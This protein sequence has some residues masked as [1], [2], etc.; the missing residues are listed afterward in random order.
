M[1]TLGKILTP[2]PRTRVVI[3]KPSDITDFFIIIKLLSWWLHSL[4]SHKGG[5]STLHDGN[6]SSSS[7]YC[8]MKNQINRSIPYF[9][10][11]YTTTLFSFLFHDDEIIM[12]SSLNKWLAHR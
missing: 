4:H 8:K 2:I 11:H 1:Y 5:L 9:S 6:N 10:V 7:V 3:V 12:S